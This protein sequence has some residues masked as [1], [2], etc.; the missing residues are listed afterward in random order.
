MT[1][2]LRD[3]RHDTIKT[4]MAFAEVGS[5]SPATRSWAVARWGEGGAPSEV[6]KAAESASSLSSLDS[7]ATGLIDR[8]IFGAVRERA[9]LFRMRGVRRTGF[10]T[11]SI[12]SS[13]AVATFVA[14]GAAAP[15]L[16]ANLDNAGLQ[17]AKLVAMTA[18]TQESLNAAPGFEGL[19]YDDLTAAYVDGLDDALL[20]PTNN[21]SGAAPAALTYGA[22]NIIA[23]G[24]IAVDLADLVE[25]FAGNLLAAYFVTA[26]ETAAALAAKE[27]GR[28]LGARGGELLGVPLLTSNASPRGQLALIDAGGVMAAWDSDNSLVIEVGREGSIQ[29]DSAPTGS[30]TTPAGTA[31]VS[32]WQTN[33][34]AFRAVGFVTW[35][36]AKAGAVSILT[37]LEPV[38]S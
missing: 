27:V 35:A 9:I 28:D 8:Q 6:S 11:R 21:G 30:S 26:P 38:A 25:A 5:D 20:D 13:P 34:R 19:L 18:A 12:T 24:D 7:I 2:K 29:F 1:V 37:G 32:L 15:L 33:T 10:T 22:P 17:P 14:E 23:T 4:A 31:V 3:T 16:E 36:L